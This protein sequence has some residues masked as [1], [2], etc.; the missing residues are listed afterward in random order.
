LINQPIILVELKSQVPFL[1]LFKHPN[2]AQTS[3]NRFGNQMS[4]K[5]RTVLDWFL[6]KPGLKRP[7]HEPFECWTCP[8]FISSVYFKVKNNKFYVFFQK[9]LKSNH[10]LFCTGGSFGHWPSGW[11]RGLQWQ[12]LQAQIFHWRLKGLK[13]LHNPSSK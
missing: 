4:D 1:K 12:S 8:V 10:G 9:F 6:S 11:K 2:Q 13:F 3:E 5:N 7:K